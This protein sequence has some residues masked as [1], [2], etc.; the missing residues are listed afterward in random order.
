MQTN[1]N[2]NDINIDIYNNNDNVSDNDR[3]EENKS[4]LHFTKTVVEHNEILDSLSI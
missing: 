2:P 3:A 1:D 4:S